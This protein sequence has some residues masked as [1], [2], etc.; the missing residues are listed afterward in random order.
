MI[1]RKLNMDGITGI[2]GCSV[3]TLLLLHRDLK[4]F[5]ETPSILG[6]IKNQKNYPG[7]GGCV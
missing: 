6:R 5:M 2:I 1:Q 3:L 7:L 4:M